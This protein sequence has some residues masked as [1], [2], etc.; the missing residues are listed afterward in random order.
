VTR[1]RPEG[2]RPGLRCATC[3]ELIDDYTHVQGPDGTP[4]AGDVSICLVCGT[5]RVYY[6]TGGLREPTP[7]EMAGFQAD[8]FIMKAARLAPEFNRRWKDL[9]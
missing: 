9:Q 1:P 4:H 5:I 3:G 2:V 6:G 7:E 8:P